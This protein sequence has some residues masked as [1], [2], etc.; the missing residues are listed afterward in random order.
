MI[1]NYTKLHAKG[2]RGVPKL[3][4]T[5]PQGGE[6]VKLRFSIT[7]SIDD[8]PKKVATACEHGYCLRTHW[9]TGILV[10]T[11]NF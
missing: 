11:T 5:T 3:H 7:R 2:G 9:D 10:T 4:A 6:G 1:F 8:L